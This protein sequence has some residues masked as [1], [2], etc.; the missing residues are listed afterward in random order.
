M[1]TQRSKPLAPFLGD[2]VPGLLAGLAFLLSLSLGLEEA[3]PLIRIRR[4]WVSSRNAP[5]FHSCFPN[6]FRVRARG[7]PSH[8]FIAT[9]YLP[10][11]AHRCGAPPG[12]LFLGLPYKGVRSVASEPVFAGG[13]CQYAWAAGWTVSHSETGGNL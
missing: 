5:F 11:T 7:E 3:S 8:Y 13:D 6:I 1:S 2:L 4:L 12:T 9:A 10:H